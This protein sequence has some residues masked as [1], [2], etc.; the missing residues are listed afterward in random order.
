MTNDNSA[1]SDKYSN[2]QET[3][4]DAKRLFEH[5]DEVSIE[6]VKELN[7]S[8]FDVDE[9]I[10]EA[11]NPHREEHILAYLYWIEDLTQEEIADRLGYSRTYV[12]QNM[13]EIPTGP[14]P[15]KHRASVGYYINDDRG[16]LWSCFQGETKVT[17]EYRLL[18][19]AEYGIEAFY[20][21][22]D[23]DGDDEDTEMVV[24]HQNGHPL[25][26]RPENL[27]VMEKEEHDD[28]HTSDDSEFIIE[29]GEAKLVDAPDADA[30]R[31][32]DEWLND[33]LDA[34][35]ENDIP[36]ADEVESECLKQAIERLDDSDELSVEDVEADVG[37]Q[38][39]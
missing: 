35:D 13:A 8:K 19:V 30:R 22:E 1:D 25:D 26:N 12:S 34:L 28:L 27:E 5:N 20:D 15:T 17:L 6:H 21:D 9:A 10:S 2:H 37:R 16:K 39:A 24:H 3:A 18:A 33:D 14:D 4:E 29:N 32:V 7:W 36:D 23:G 31:A 38:G 11:E